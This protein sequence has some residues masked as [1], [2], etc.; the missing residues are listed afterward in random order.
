MSEFSLLGKCVAAGALALVVAT[1]H[2]GQAPDTLEQQAIASRLAAT[3]M[4]AGIGRAGDR[5]VAVGV[6]GHILTSED[7]GASWH[8][9]TDVPVTV[10][11]TD[12][13]FNDDQHGW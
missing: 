12:V 7:E 13:C 8:Q 1:G 11:L 3:S 10:T 5:L 6:K 2:G 9:T 4:L